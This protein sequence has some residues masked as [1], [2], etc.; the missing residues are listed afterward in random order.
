MSVSSGLTKCFFAQASRKS[1]R[2]IME[3]LSGFE[4]TRKESPF[5]T[6]YIMTS[7]SRYKSLT[8]FW[9]M[10]VSRKLIE[11]SIRGH[12]SSQLFGSFDPIQPL[13][14]RCSRQLEY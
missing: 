13:R 9:K 12:L 7:G 8:R 2:I 4:K 11:F 5:R 1:T 6:P 10:R 14:G 3:I